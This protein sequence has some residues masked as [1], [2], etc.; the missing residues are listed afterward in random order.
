MKILLIGDLH[1]TDKPRDAYRFNIFGWVLKQQEK[2]NPE[3]TIFT[4]DVTDKKD[5]HSASLVNK[6]VT[7]LSKLKPPVYIIKGNHDYIDEKEPY[8]KFLC[9]IDGLHFI[10]KPELIAP[11][12]GALPHFRSENE[13]IKA[14]IEF[15]NLDFLFIHQTM[16]GAIAESG[17][18][19]NGFD[20]AAF[21][22]LGPQVQVF[23]GDVHKPQRASKVTYVGSPYR[24]RFGDDFEP[25]CLLIEDSTKKNLYF[26]CP[27]KWA[28]VIKSED[29]I[30]NNEDL[31]EGDQV[32]IVIELS[33]E[34]IVEGQTYIKK[35]KDAC[36]K[37]GLEI[38]GCSIKILTSV[39]KVTGTISTHEPKDILNTFCKIEK[40]SSQIKQTGIDLL[41]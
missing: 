8:F 34:E 14:C 27:R 26:K 12:I 40:V 18:S 16:K 41:V 38:F 31:F 29:E 13:F 17:V 3:L 11:K 36:H 35:V 6:I 20:T 21:E 37:K 25:R 39:K 19:L 7:K 5:W 30:L 23:A 2:Y 4:G 1:L 15:S 32:K 28:L 9:K 24:I 22:P 10:T 33:K